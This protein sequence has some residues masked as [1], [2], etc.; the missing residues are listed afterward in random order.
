M[1]KRNQAPGVTEQIAQDLEPVPASPDEVWLLGEYV[2]ITLSVTRFSQNDSQWKNDVMQTTSSTCT[3]CTIGGQGCLLT[4]A[5]MVFRYYGCAYVTPKVLN[6]NMGIYACPF[7]Y[8][9]AAGY[10]CGGASW[11]GL[12][13]FT[14][15]RMV[16]Y[17]NSG[18]PPILCL[19]KY[20]S[21]VRK[22][23][24]VTVKKVQGDWELSSSYW[25]NDP[26]N[27][28]EVNLADLMTAGGWTACVQ[29]AVYS[30]N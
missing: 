5:S 16:S 27:G 15:L 3:G 7:Y 24:W 8:E 10:S 6:S 29:L 2:N 22:T 14:Y 23:H 21:G 25:V 18:W 12:Y 11:Y 13:S 19:E 30:R 20:V 4:S 1:A 9:R 17:L 26:W 28:Q